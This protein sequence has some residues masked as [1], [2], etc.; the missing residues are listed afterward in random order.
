MT[1]MNVLVVIDN[2]T[3]RIV[4]RDN[5]RNWPNMIPATTHVTV[6][7]WKGFSNYDPSDWKDFNLIFPQASPDPIKQST[8]TLSTVEIER[9]TFERHR[10]NLAW[11]W[12]CGLDDQNRSAEGMIPGV[13][14]YSNEREKNL[15]QQE[16][17]HLHELIRKDIVR[18]WPRIWQCQNHQQVTDVFTEIRLEGINYIKRYI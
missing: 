4:M 18:F 14:I 17:E 7:N 9:L 8:S 5:W 13:E 12:L 15:L 3:E 2:R 16:K 11:R 6:R 10:A 1:W